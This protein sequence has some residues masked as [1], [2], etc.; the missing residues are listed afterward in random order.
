[1]YVICLTYCFPFFSVI[2][3]FFD[4]ASCIFKLKDFNCFDSFVTL[5]FIKLGHLGH[6]L[7]CGNREAMHI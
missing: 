2:V 7:T 1:M 3:T 5:P 6:C 4:V